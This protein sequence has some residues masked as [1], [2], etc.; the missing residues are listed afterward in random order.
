MCVIKQLLLAVRLQTISKLSI[1]LFGVTIKLLGC[2]MSASA[3]FGYI[4]AKILEKEKL[5]IM[6]LNIAA[7]II[8][9]TKA[10]RFLAI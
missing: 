5:V 9:I 3:T 6:R 7:E 8:C 1:I 2:M 10:E 4:Y